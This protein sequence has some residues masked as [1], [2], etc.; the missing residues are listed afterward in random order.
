[1][2]PTK[3]PLSLSANAQ[4]ALRAM[5]LPGHSCNWTEV[6]SCIPLRVTW[7]GEV[8]AEVPYSEIPLSW[9]RT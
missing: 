4:K 1:M 6:S 3:G 7:N 8:E 5:K 9:L 2:I